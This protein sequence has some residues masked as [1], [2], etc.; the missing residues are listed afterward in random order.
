[1]KKD[2]ELFLKTILEYRKKVG[3]DSFVIICRDYKDIPRIQTA[4]INILEDLIQNNCLTS[5]SKVT[6]LEGH[7]SINLTLDGI[8]YFDD[9]KTKGNTSNYIFNISG[10]QLNFAKDNGTIN[11]AVNNDGGNYGKRQKL[12]SRTQEYADKWNNNMFLNDFDEWDGNTGVNIKLSDMYIDD[13]LPHFV[14]RSNNKIFNNLKEFLSKYIIGNNR[15]NQMLLILGQP[16]IGKSTLITWITANFKDRINDILVNQFASDLKNIDKY[17]LDNDKRQLILGELKLSLNDLDGKVLILDGFDE[18]SVR[19]DRAIILN[20]LYRDLISE[21]LLHGFSLIITCRENYIRNMYDVECDYITLQP[22]QANQIQSF[23]KVYSEKAK[24]IILEETITNILKNK[25]ILGI[26]LI[27]YMVLAL[28]ITIEKEGS[29][30][31]VYDQ[32]FSSKDGGIYERCFEN[33]KKNKKER[34]DNPHWISVIKK[35]IHQI[36]RDIAIWMFENNPD[37]AFITKSEYHNI[38]DAIIHEYQTQENEYIERDSLIG[39]YFKQVK[40]CEGVDTE[41]V[42]FVHRSIYE[43]F[44][45]ETIYSSIKDALLELSEESKEQLAG[46]IAVYL[47]DGQITNTI[48]EYLQYMILKLYQRLDGEKK[49]IFYQWWESTIDMMMVSGMF[50][51]TKRNI[52]DYKNIIYKE[53]QCFI[54]YIIILRLLLETSKNSYVMQDVDKDQK[55]MYIKLILAQSRIRLKYINLSRMSL[56]RINL[57]GENLEEVDLRGTDLSEADLS[58]ANLNR[59]DLRGADLR[60]T[61]FRGA[62]LLGANLLEANTRGTI[63]EESSRFEYYT[64]KVLS[65]LKKGSSKLLTDKNSTSDV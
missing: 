4:M 39:G 51:Y 61:D 2:S 41:E 65:E 56:T 12:K 25:E 21:N 34:Y 60:G 7:V 59:A 47:K 14:R 33:N 42:C 45:A 6:D 28:D 31:E 30:V 32:I 19:N 46:N 5:Q 62:N 58:G 13:H 40:H 57:V 16:G 8:A 18:I 35:Q 27:L 54:N 63:F 11:A 23:C 22:W 52:Q 1:M 50:Y 17:D 36:S 20:S 49:G 9:T 26:P 53:A 15:K 37:K 55:E 24:C 43:Y 64:W 3:K 29:I 44:V 48:G 10:G 38:C